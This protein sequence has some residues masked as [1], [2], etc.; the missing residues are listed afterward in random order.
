MTPPIHADQISPDPWVNPFTPT[1]VRDHPSL[2]LLL[3]ARLMRTVD[4]GPWTKE[5]GPGTKE[6]GPGTRD[7]GPATKDQ[8]PGTRDQ[9]PRTRDQG[10]VHSCI[11]GSTT[12]FFLCLNG[13]SSTEITWHCKH[14]KGRGLMK[15]YNNMGKPWES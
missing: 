3:E 15:S 8:G 7:Q 14:Y 1:S 6:H 5:H 13:K 9:G 4:Q 11:Q 10:L 12:G 2:V